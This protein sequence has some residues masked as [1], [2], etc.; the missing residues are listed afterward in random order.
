MILYVLI[1]V[2]GQMPLV[3]HNLRTYTNRSIELLK[4][5]VQDP[6]DFKEVRQAWEVSR[7]V[8]KQMLASG[9]VSRVTLSSQ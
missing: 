6:M 9:Y 4:D 5:W 8:R 2:S 1:I 7:P 3:K